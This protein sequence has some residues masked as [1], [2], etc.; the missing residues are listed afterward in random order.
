MASLSD[1]SDPVWLAGQAGFKIGKT[2]VEKGVDPST[3]R[4]YIVFNI[5]DSLV[6]LRQAINYHGVPGDVMIS[7]SELLNNWSVTKT[8]PPFQMNEPPPLPP[9]IATDVQKL[10]ILKAIL[11]VHFEHGSKH[12]LKFYRR[13]DEVRTSDAPI[14]NGD[15]VIAPVC[16][17]AHITTKNTI[18]NT[19]RS[20][21]QY[22]D[23]AYF[24]LPVSKQQV[25]DEAW[26]PKTIVSPFY[27]VSTVRTKSAANM[28]HD[29]VEQN[30]I[31]VPV[32]NNSRGLEPNSKLAFYVK[33]K[34]KVAPFAQC[35]SL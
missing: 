20:I 30:G 5:T 10:E 1:L 31:Q 29:V 21:G 3:E 2:C 28:V 18:L 17:L 9:S 35:A 24:L 15:L 7:L 34:D 27:W 13:P 33:P 14:K 4:L 6:T 12:T 11:A 23:V 26:D 8:E 32:L 25:K 19:A 22:D 16:S